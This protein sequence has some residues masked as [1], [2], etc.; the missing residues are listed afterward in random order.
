[1][2]SVNVSRAGAKMKGRSPSSADRPIIDV[3]TIVESRPL[4]WYAVRLVLVSWLVTF[5]DGYDMNVFAFAAPYL[6]PAY[7]LDKV[8]L[9]LVA[10]A[11]IAGT[12]FGGLVFGYLGDRIGRRTTIIIATA[13]FGCLTLALTLASTYIEFMALRFLG[14][15]A[16]GGAIPLTW[17]LGTEYVPSRFR[18][19]AVT[20]IMLGYG[21]GVSAA[22]PI[23]IA[24]IPRF[25][26]ISV[27]TFGGIASI[28]AAAVLLAALPESLR[29]LAA[30]GAR[31]ER[32]ARAI[33]RLAPDCE[34]P[35][36][37]RFVLSDERP[38]SAS[39]H[40][41]AVLF[42]GKLRYITP[43]LWA[44]YFASSMTTFF[45]AQW[46][47]IVYEGLGFSRESAAWVTSSQSLAGSTGGLLLM[48][49]TDRFGAVSVGIFPAIAVPLLLAVAFTHVTQ[50]A[51]IALIV[52]AALF[53]SGS[54]FGITSIIGTFYPTSH[55]A[56]GTGWASSIAKFG[57]IAGPSIGGVVLSSGLPVQH[58]FAVMTI[59]PA[60][61]CLCMLAIATVQRRWRRS[62]TVVAAPAP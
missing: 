15:I 58:T 21:L 10:S 30:R 37:A 36:G 1:M 62:A 24:L 35:E 3:A 28:A 45:L 54:H 25:G 29:F 38:A 41:V 2:M 55:R 40:S 19:T 26:W 32:L 47:P 39:P 11:G 5:F 56:L 20:L 31:P 17:A 8:V 60:T 16:L 34:V 7:H 53:L 43:L 49:L 33:R 18:A 59:C 4:G 27:F 42:E 46:G 14:G 12:L 51:F 57:S 6:A 48:R 22:G 52:M 9:G 23:S 61:L 44:G 13:G 50:G